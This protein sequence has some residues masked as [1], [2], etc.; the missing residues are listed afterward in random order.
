MGGSLDLGFVSQVM[1][2]NDTA[3]LGPIRNKD[4]S[5]HA[6]DEHVAIE[7]LVDTAKEILLYLTLDSE[8]N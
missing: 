1:G 6:P 7:D 8:G 3:I 2:S 5:A 4:R